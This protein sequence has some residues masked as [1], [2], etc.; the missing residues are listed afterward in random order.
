LTRGSI[1]A[2]KRFDSRDGPPQWQTVS[3]MQSEEN[4]Y[5]LW[6]VAR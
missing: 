2:I 6:I 3:E 1:G 5:K 4:R